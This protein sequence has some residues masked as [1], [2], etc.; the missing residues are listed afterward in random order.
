MSY[1]LEFRNEVEHEEIMEKL[2]KAKKA[3][4]EAWEALEN[5]ASYSER[6]YPNMGYRED[7]DD[8]EYRRGGRARNGRYSY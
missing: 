7:Y 8:V 3:V 2:K 1:I 5:S 4:C 6:R